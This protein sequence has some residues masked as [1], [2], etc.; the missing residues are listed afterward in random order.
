MRSLAAALFLS[1]LVAAP[2]SA[3]PGVYSRAA[4]PDQTTLDRLNLTTVWSSY[5]PTHGRQD[6][7]ARVQPVDDTQIFVQT[8]SG[9]L[10]ALDVKTG[11]EQWKFKYP[12]AFADGYPVGVNEQFVYSVNV[13]NLFCQQR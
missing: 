9:V 10:I 4:P 8:K 1:V 5:L 12:A 6:G 2:A 13:S 3:Q 7:I 11:R